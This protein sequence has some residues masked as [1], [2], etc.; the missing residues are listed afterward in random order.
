LDPLYV[1]NEGRLV[2]FVQA[3]QAD[4][5]LEVLRAE[6]VS[7]GAAQIGTVTADAAGLVTL[8]S[9]IGARRVMDRLSGEQLPRI[10]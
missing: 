2:A 3:T 10:C 4:R 9:R 6:P 7:R 8:R 1:A 5:A